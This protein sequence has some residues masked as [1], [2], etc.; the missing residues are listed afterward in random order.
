MS[1]FQIHVKSPFKNAKPVS[2]LGRVE[3]PII[4]FNE[5]TNSE[6]I[7]TI[8]A[9]IIDSEYEIIIGRPTIRKNGLLVKCHN[10]ILYGTREKMILDDSVT[11]ENYKKA[12]R[13]ILNHLVNATYDVKDVKGNTNEYPFAKNA[14]KPPTHRQCVGC[15]ETRKIHS[16]EGTVCK[17][18]ATAEMDKPLPYVCSACYS[19]DLTLEAKLQENHEAENEEHFQAQTKLSELEENRHGQTW[20]SVVTARHSQPSTGLC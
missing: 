19:P 11:S 14:P 16:T 7:I 13:W 4:I 18:V 2:C 3:L 9:L 10:Q 20:Q 8:D 1:S 17:V 5:L 12:D 15:N 6:D